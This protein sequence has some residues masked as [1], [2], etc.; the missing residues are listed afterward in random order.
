LSRKAARRL[1]KLGVKVLT[2]TK[3]EKVD[4]QGVVAGGKRIASATVL[5]TAGVAASPVAR[6]LAI[7]TDRAGR[8]PVDPF[9]MVPG[10][11][12]VFAVGDVAA[13]A[14]HPTFPHLGD[15]IWKS[16]TTST[17][18]R[19][20]AG[21]M[22]GTIQDRRRVAMARNVADQFIETLAAAGVKRIYGIV[23]DSKLGPW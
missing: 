9:L 23:G 16:F 3:V 20:T 2:G 4:D 18:G 17:R 7:P 21:H 13:P 6:T 5:W 12:G 15:R 22:D 1:E 8:L 11:N 10:V 19:K 14:K